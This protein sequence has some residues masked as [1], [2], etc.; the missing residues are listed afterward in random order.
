M[1]VKQDRTY[2]I[3]C[4]RFIQRYNM[5]QHI[6][7]H[8]LDP[9]EMQKNSINIDLTPKPESLNPLKLSLPSFMAE[10]GLNMT[11]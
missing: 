4:R 2:F 8:R 11:H 10:N 6:K 7:T 5:K 9:E 3:I 1:K